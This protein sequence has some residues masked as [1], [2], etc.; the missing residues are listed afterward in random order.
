VQWHGTDA[1]GRDHRSLEHYPSDRGLALLALLRDQD[2]GGV[3]TLEVFRAADLESSRD[4]LD[5][6]LSE[7]GWSLPTRRGSV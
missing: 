6:W 4:R 5:Q 7:L 2:Y 1:S 3:L